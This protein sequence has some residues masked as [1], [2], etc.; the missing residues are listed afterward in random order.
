MASSKQSFVLVLLVLA[1]LVSCISATLLCEDLPIDLCAFAV[2]STGSRCVLEKE[3]S[4][5]G[6]VE[7]Q[8]Q[9]S[10]VSANEFTEWVETDDCVHSCGIDRLTVGISSD[11]LVESRFVKA[12]CSVDCQ[13]GCP[14][15]VDLFEKLSEGEGVALS[16]VC[17]VQ[18]MG[19]ARR[20]MREASTSHFASLSGNTL[21]A[22][23]ASNAV[24]S[25]VGAFAPQG[26]SATSPEAAPSPF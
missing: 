4:F 26:P 13:S 18:S 8:C 23:E 11:A 14:N 25:P 2:S 15:V 19:A 1:G 22:W 20:G 9:T 24:H 16:Q 5:Q 7:Y 21:N 12:L 3:I 17:A 10:V 6:K